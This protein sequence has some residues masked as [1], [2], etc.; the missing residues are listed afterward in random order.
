MQNTALGGLSSKSFSLPVITNGGFPF[1]ICSGRC[2]VLYAPIDRIPWLTNVKFLKLFMFCFYLL[3]ICC[4]FGQRTVNHWLQQRK[5][6]DFISPILR[7]DFFSFSFFL[8]SCWLKKGLKLAIVSFFFSFHFLLFVLFLSLNGGYGGVML[9]MLD[10]NHWRRYEL[11]WRIIVFFLWSMGQY[12]NLL[13][14]V[15]FI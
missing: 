2:T 3:F 10:W 9:K 13:F 7:V 14:V 6:F 4:C 11:K 12:G 15:I 5:C 8:L 1:C